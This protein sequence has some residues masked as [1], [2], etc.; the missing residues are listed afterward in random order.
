[1]KTLIDRHHEQAA[2]GGTR[3]VPGCGFDSVPSDLGA[4]LAAR[5]A[6]ELGVECGPVKAF[7]Q[8]SGG[9]NGGTLATFMLISGDPAQN[10]QMRDP[11]LLN[12]PGARSAK[13]GA[14]RDPTF[15]AFDGDITAWTSPFA[16]G[17]INTRVVRR[18][19]ALFEAWNESYGSH[20]SYQEYMAFPGPFGATLAT[21]VAAG[22]RIAQTSM[23]FGSTRSLLAPLIPKPGTGPSEATIRDG[24]YRCELVARTS[25]G[26]QIRGLVAG[27]GDPGNAATVVFACESAL[28]LA[29]DSDE[30]PGGRARGG[31]LTPATALGEVL[32]RRLRAAGTT[33]EASIAKG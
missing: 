11:E 19:A 22:T 1:V 26:R 20:F 23:S 5:C 8:L 27:K 13:G 4:F 28:G 2:A 25:D 7:Y 3:I 31:V 14:L 33:L 18:S 32:I 15:A 29:R 16:M 17:P 6:R 24:W 12:P 10:A 9:V 30:L 21:T